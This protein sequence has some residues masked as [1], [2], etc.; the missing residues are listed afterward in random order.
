[1]RAVSHARIADMPRQRLGV[2]LVVPPPFDVM[3]D[4]LRLACG[5]PMLGSVPPHLTLVSPVNVRDSDVPTAMR[6]LR[7]AAKTARPLRL[8]L[9]PPTTFLPVNP[10]LYLGVSGQLDDLRALRDAVS[11]GPFER[12]L[13]W[14]WV[15][16]VTLAD[17]Q[18][19]ARI[20]AAIAAL[21]D[22]TVDVVFDR[23]TVLRE[24]RDDEGRVWRPI[25]D[26]ALA[27]PAV[28]GR[29]G[30]P[31]ELT[32][33]ERLDPEGQAL[34]DR[35]WA[36]LDP[37]VFGDGWRPRE[38]VAI[39]ARR[40]DEVVGVAAGWVGGGVAYLADL[41]V[42]ADARGQGIG[43][44]L[45]AAF[46]SLAAE[47]G[48]D[49]VAVRAVAGEPAEGFYRRHGWVEDV[50]WDWQHGRQWVQLRKRPS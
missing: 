41:M 37:V 13:R 1:M 36:A 39:T 25:A 35:S 20:D 4:A 8:V 3:V 40:E 50:R 23:V 18:D 17:E 44:H 48:F 34:L 24:E 26:A 7:R 14:E 5:D 30:L 9:G 6:I 11:T 43:S 21:T 28:I 49:D 16:H 10:V 32:T 31:L 12:P 27:A 33:G 42:A 29:G 2:V 46:E 15:P 45:L 19:P 47:R 22:F 38:P